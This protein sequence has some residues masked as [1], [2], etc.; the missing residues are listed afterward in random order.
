MSY[1]TAYQ[2]TSTKDVLKIICYLLSRVDEMKLRAD[3]EQ[4]RLEAAAQNAELRERLVAIF[5]AAAGN[6]EILMRHQNGCMI[7]EDRA[8][9][10][11]TEYL[12]LMKNNNLILTELNSYMKL[13]FIDVKSGHSW[14]FLLNRDDFNAIEAELAAN[15]TLVDHSQLVPVLV[16]P[17]T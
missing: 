12:R 2:V 13:S 8:P 10:D 15:A 3:V 1:V 6:Y 14:A 5:D 16:V 7:I 4:R 9:G 17:A 11:F